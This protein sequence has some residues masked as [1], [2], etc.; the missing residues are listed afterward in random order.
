MVDQAD[1]CLMLTR[2][3]GRGGRGWDESVE[4]SLTKC[5]W[6]FIVRFPASTYF[7]KFPVECSSGEN[8]KL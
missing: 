6:E 5:R 4:T 7:G 3:D 8:T 1:Q 2:R